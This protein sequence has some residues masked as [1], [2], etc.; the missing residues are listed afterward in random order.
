MM[1]Y[2]SL[3]SPSEMAWKAK[4]EAM[5]GRAD[6]DGVWGRKGVLVLK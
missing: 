6:G 3:S 4:G 2:K 1:E 5:D